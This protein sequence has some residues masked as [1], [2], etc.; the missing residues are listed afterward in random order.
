MSDACIFSFPM[1]FNCKT[2]FNFTRVKTFA[3][4]LLFK[5]MTRLL[6]WHRVWLYFYNLFNL[7]SMK[8]DIIQTKYLHVYRFDVWHNLRERYRDRWQRVI[9]FRNIS[10]EKIWKQRQIVGSGQ[11]WCDWKCDTREFSRIW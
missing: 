6:M 4:S 2:L 1:N 5:Y 9:H 3:V 11:Q 10:G 7:I 8:L